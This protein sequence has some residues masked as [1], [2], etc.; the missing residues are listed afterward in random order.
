MIFRMPN[1]KKSIPIRTIK[2]NFKFQHIKIE[3]ILFGRGDQNEY[4]FVYI[5]SNFNFT[6]I[7]GLQNIVFNQH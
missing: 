2:N 4:I 6:Y 1:L 3:Y 5:G 7:R